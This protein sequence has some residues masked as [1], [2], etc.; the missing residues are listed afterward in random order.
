[1]LREFF[2]A[3]N[4][5][6]RAWAWLGGLSIVGH[7]FLRAY[8]KYLMNDWMGRFYDVGGSA[9]EVSSDDA[10]G[11]AEGSRKITGLLVEF[12]KLCLPGVFVHP[13]FK[14]VTNRW[15]LSWRVALIDAYLERWAAV[16]LRIENGAQR[17]HE[18]TQRFARGLQTCFVTV[19]DSII[20]IGV[21][22][23]V[24][25]DL[26]SEV[27]PRPM[28]SYWL[29]LVCAGIAV[30][31]L[32]ISVVL[33]WSLIALEV[34]NQKV[35]ADLRRDLVLH[36]D[37]ASRPR[38]V[39]VARRMR[40][41]DVADIDGLYSENPHIEPERIPMDL[42]SAFT[43]VIAALERNYKKLYGRF[44][45]FSLWLGAYEQFVVI[46]P[47]FI[48]GPLLFS[49]ANRITLGKVSQVANAFGNVFDALNILSDRWIEV[50]DWLSVM[51]RLNEF[52]IHVYGLSSTR[53]A[54]ISGVEISSAAPPS[55]HTERC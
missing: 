11:L 33:G 12:L 31:G 42:K 10:E 22:A 39:P 13:L 24:I 25:I 9:H 50:T 5:W 29:F 52:E 51:R 43:M 37:R 1:M 18:D 8:V 55:L 32:I 26:G 28:P 44:A 27:Q 46:L 21:F 41:E 54:L 3:R 2:N 36:E 17:I 7:A 48:A 47:Y 45:A 23:P 14:F 20:T 38:D 6:L 15:V 19:L 4:K 49:S 16:D 34:Q 30:I 35:E 40:A 53:T